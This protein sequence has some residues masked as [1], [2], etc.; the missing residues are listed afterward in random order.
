MNYTPD[1]PRDSVDRAIYHALLIWSYPSQLRFRQANEMEHPDIEFLFAQGYHED[2]YQFDGKGSVLAHAFYPEEHLGG[3][4]HYD[5]DEDWTVYRENEYGLMDLFSVTVHELG[6]SLGLMHSN[7]PDAIMFPYYRGYSKSIKLHS[8]DIAAVRK[9]YGDPPTEV[10]TPSSLNTDEI[11]KETNDY[12]T[13]P[14]IITNT[15]EVAAATIVTSASTKTETATSTNPISTLVLNNHKRIHNET[16]IT[17]TTMTITSTTTSTAA[18]ATTTKPV[19]TTTTTAAAT[20]LITLNHSYETK[21]PSITKSATPKSTNHP[22]QSYVERHRSTEQI[23]I[24]YTD[25]STLDLCDGFYDAITMYKGILFIFK[26]QYFWQYDRRG[27]D[28]SSPMINNA[29]WLGLP[30]TLTKI[31]AAYERADGRLM[32]FSG[33]QYWLFDDNKISVEED[34]STYPRNISSLGLPTHVDYIDAAFLWSF[35]RQAYLVSE[36]LYWALDERWN[37]VNTYDYPRDMTMWQGIDIPLDDAFVDL[38]GSTYFFKGLDFWRLN[39]TSMEAAVDYPRSIN[40]NWLFCDKPRSSSLSSSRST[41][42]V[43]IIFLTI[44]YCSSL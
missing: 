19:T 25:P 24:N 41:A 9:L 29:F 14:P 33:R 4:V 1:M 16:T 37:R 23:K 2:G 8:D 26:G 18:T 7:I 20:T 3:D 13:T 30:E 27:L 17:T 31:D 42:I 22:L 5:E 10:L 34:G 12:S 21:D 28:P 35:N 40:T 32:L 44:L 36:N 15:V 11:T 38:T 43:S 39:N 6:H